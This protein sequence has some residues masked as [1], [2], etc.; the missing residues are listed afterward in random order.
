MR[1]DDDPAVQRIHKENAERMLLAS[2]VTGLSGEIG[3]LTRIQNPQNVNQALTTAVTIRE[4]LREEKGAENFLTRFENSVGVSGLGGVRHVRERAEP[5]CYECEGRGHL[6]QQKL[7]ERTFKLS[8]LLAVSKFQFK[9][10]EASPAISVEIEGETKRLIIDTG[11]S[12]S[13]LQPGVSRRD[14]G[15]TAIKRYGVKARTSTYRDNSVYFV[16]GGKTFGH[17]FLVGPL[18]TKADGLLGSDVLGKVGTDVKF[19][20]R[21]LSGWQ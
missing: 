17:T 14:I 20:S 18:P 11:S 13:V 16:L 19:G 9:W 5:K 6:T 4:A 3:K 10:S 12:V 2:F 8:P 21:E 15:V 1:Q 7:P